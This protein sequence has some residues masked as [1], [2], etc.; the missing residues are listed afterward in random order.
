MSDRLTEMAAGSAPARLRDDVVIAFPTAPLHVSADAILASISDGIVALDN[1]WRLVY[2]NPAAQGIWGRDLRPLIGKSL[3]DVLDIAPDNPFRLA[4]MISKNNGEPIAFTGYSEIF[5]AWVDVRG[6]P[7]RDGY[8]ILFRTASP[9][10]PSVGRTVESEREREATRSINQR[11]FDTSL[12]LILVVDQRGEFLRVSPSSAGILGYAPDDMIGR[13]AQEFVHPDDLDVTRENMRR[14]RRGRLKRNFECRYIDRNGRAVP[15]VWTGIWSEPD[16]QYFFIGRDMTERV[17]LESQLRQAQKMEAVGQLTGGVAH[18]F[19]NILTVIIGMT[20]LLSEDLAHDA[21]L[22]PIVDAIDEAATRGAQLTQRMLA[23]ARKQPLQARTLDLNDVVARS[24]KLLERILGEHIAVNTV[25]AADLWRAVADPSQLEDTILNLAVNARDAMPDGGQLVIETGNAVLDE[26][27][28][29]HNVEV[30]P[31]EYVSVSITDSGSGMAPDVVERVFEPFFTTKPAGQ[32]TGL[33]LSMV[34]GFV[35]QSRGHVKIY[36]EVG[37]GTRITVYLP[38]ALAAEH[39]TAP[40]ALT[41][42]D[43]RG[44]ETVLVVEDNGAVRRVAVNMLKGFGYQVREAEDGPSALA[45]LQEPGKID[46]LFTDLIM[47]NGMDGQAL[48][49]HARA[50]RPEL[51]A[52][53]TS[54]YSEQFIKSRGTTE[55]GV[56]LL[57]KPYRTQKLAE[58]V[59]GALDARAES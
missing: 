33:G 53:F 5:A 52:L 38:R 13:N 4:Y 26:Q 47:P 8:T 1:D 15:L 3:H 43:L 14:A 56:A 42:P 49:R 46:L 24:V 41:K 21:Q 44:R 12:D 34:Y 16:G 18:D 45:I 59:R 10:R 48:L 28:A 55:A 25:L 36:S 57:S 17:A 22:K 50:L 40:A 19:N 37:H 32:G 9:D 23:F 11:I 39:G 54:G 31:G 2:A 51:K 35:K 58:A 27:Y 30:T 7:H 20:E 6:Y 29:A